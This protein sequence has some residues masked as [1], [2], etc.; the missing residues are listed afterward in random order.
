[1]N[2]TPNQRSQKHQKNRSAECES[3]QSRRIVRFDTRPLA[4][5]NSKLS[6]LEL[7]REI[8]AGAETSWTA[9][10][11]TLRKTLTPPIMAIF[12][13]WQSHA[14]EN[15][16]E[17]WFWHKSLWFFMQILI[18]IYPENKNIFRTLKKLNTS[19]FIT[20]LFSSNKVLQYYLI[21]N[22]FKHQ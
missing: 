7:F 17:S 14:D 5:V 22:T 3:N 11:R 9:C 13:F 15:I 20:Y 10:G 4:A 21:F 6:R 2:K 19:E 1:M 18:I 8:L 12:F 16:F